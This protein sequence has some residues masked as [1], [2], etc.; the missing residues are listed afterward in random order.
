ML[1]YDILSAMAKATGIFVF[2]IVY[3]IGLIVRHSSESPELSL[4]SHTYS[5][6]FQVTGPLQ[7]W[8]YAQAH[9]GTMAEANSRSCEVHRARSL[10]VQVAVLHTLMHRQHEQSLASSPIAIQCAAWPPQGERGK[11][12]P[13]TGGRRIIEYAGSLSLFRMIHPP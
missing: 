13:R 3:R 9:L 4:S 8:K 5:V 1:L 7:P 10:A 6:R 11:G 2:W 12:G